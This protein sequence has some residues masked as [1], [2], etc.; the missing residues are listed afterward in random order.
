MYV[1]NS[2]KL[3]MYTGMEQLHKWVVDGGNQ[4]SQCW[5]GNKQEKE[6]KILY[7]VMD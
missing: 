7:M 6:V 1:N 2:E 3:Y 4:V 5:S